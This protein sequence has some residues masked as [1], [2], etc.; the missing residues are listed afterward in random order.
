MISKILKLRNVGLLQD[1]TQTGAVS[2]GK[3]TAVYADNGSG[4]STLAAVLRACQLGDAARLNARRTIDGTSEPEVKFQLST[5]G[6]IEFKANSWTGALSDIIVFD[7]EFVEQNVYSG[8]EVRSDQRQSLLE[9]ALGHQTVQLKQRIDQLT[10][11]IETQ[12]RKRTAVE[13]TLT[14]VAPPYSTEQFIAL[15]PV[16][17]AQQTID[18]LKKRIEAAKNSQ[19]LL[20]RKDPTE[21]ACIQIDTV[22]IFS[23]LRMELRDIEQAAEDIVETHLSRHKSGNFEDWLSRGQQYI[24][25]SDCPFCGQSVGAS[26]L[27]EAY[28]SYFNQGYADLKKQVAAIEDVI[29]PT[30]AQSQLD[31]VR[32]NVAT[33]TARIE[34]WADQLA[35]SAPQLDGAA[36]SVA[37]QDVRERLLPLVVAKRRAPLVGV[38][39][40]ADFDAIT[41]EMATI[42]QAIAAY[43]KA[44]QD[45]GCRI[46]EFKQKLGTENPT[47]L[48]N[49]IRHL[50]AAQ[51]RDRADVVAAVSEYH[52][53]ET[54]R[55]RLDHEKTR[56]RQKL[57][58][59]MQSNLQEYQASINE[60][61]SRF[62]AEFSI[63]QL[64]STYLGGG[65]PRSDYGLRV[66][67]KTV[68]LGSRADVATGHSFATILSE[69]DKR[70]LAF[71]FFVA[72]L[73]ADGNLASKLVVLDDPV[74]S[75]DRNRR[76]QSIRLIADLAGDCQQLLVLSH[77][78]Y[79]VR[80]FKQQ[81]THR[82]QLVGTPHVLTIKPA[83]CGYSVFAQCDIDEVCS[84][85]YYRH[86]R[87]VSDYV[88]GKS[89]ASS[90][91]V[92]KALRPLLEGYYHRRFPGR[93]ARNQMFGRMID[94]F[95]DPQ[96][97][98]PLS[99][100]RP[101][102]KEMY[103]I[104]DYA[105]QFHHDSGGD[106]EN[107]PVVDAEL[108]GMAK[109][110]LTLVYQNG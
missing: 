39:C 80:E 105:R 46:G 53:A 50:E 71:A 84:S 19:A 27:I 104:N 91:D 3:V 66:R 13:K 37:L 56:A 7:A 31:T 110:A 11:E 100:L 26:A 96:T 92:A 81:L 107:V 43:N 75:F 14:A 4:K 41:A 42:A 55:E 8:L 33:N 102:T 59:L 87:L 69:A 106:P 64:K 12:T 23:V 65:Q 5:G 63:E 90:R 94:T 88:D 61:L 16:A 95:A 57:D 62:G 1:A 36:L 2:L 6:Q 108:R 82:S 70:T 48:A 45:V 83:A 72:R 18:T 38:G 97:P 60:L 78:P 25:G 73:R 17:N 103:E 40:A 98:V 22:Q 30:I 10:Q 44:V 21:I 34:A 77:D 28:R 85:E 29:V 86:H 79:F 76:H 109:R 20:M 99:F 32:A 24:D 89:T 47:V 9:F 52:K 49:E 58:A 67:N 101:F 15:Q 74:A 68:K 35:V 93:I 54:E 51:R